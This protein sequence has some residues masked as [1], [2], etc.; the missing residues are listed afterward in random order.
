MESLDVV[1]K[2]TMYHLDNIG[3]RGLYYI[4]GIQ[5]DYSGWGNDFSPIEKDNFLLNDPRVVFSP[6][7]YGYSV[8]G[9]DS[10]DDD[11][12]EFDKWF[13]FLKELSSNAIVITEFGGFYKDIDMEWH[14]KLFYYLKEKN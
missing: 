10:I 2:T 7:V 1:C 14:K 11:K 4:E 12:E 3:Y 9:E 13:G 5:T 8:R 6:H